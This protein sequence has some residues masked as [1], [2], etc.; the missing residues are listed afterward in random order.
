MFVCKLNAVI[1]RSGVFC[2]LI[3]KSSEGSSYG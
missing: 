2:F 3:R 1:S